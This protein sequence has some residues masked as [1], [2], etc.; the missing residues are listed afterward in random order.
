LG[1]FRVLQ[2]GDSHTAARAFAAAWR[3]HLQA[4][5]GDGGWGF[6][7]PWAS[8]AAP[9]CG[10]SPG[11]TLHQPSLRNGTDGLSGPGGA[12]LQT[13]RAGEA[14]WVE[15]PFRHLRIHLLRQP[16]GGRASIRVD[17]RESSQVDLNGPIE[18]LC[19]EPEL[20][21]EGRRLEIVALGGAV[22][23]LGVA[24]ENG[25]GATYSALGVNGA[26][27]SWLLRSE[28]G[29]FESVL[30]RERPDVVIL[31]FGTNEASLGDFEPEAYRR[32]L[33]SVLSRVRSGLPGGAVLLLGP[34][35]SHL[36]RARPGA[37]TAVLKAQQEAARGIDGLFVPLREA[38]GGEGA[39]Q[40]WSR[41]GLALKDRIHYSAEGYLRLARAGLGPLFA[42]M[43][44]S[45]PGLDGSE[46]PRLARALAGAFELPAQSPR[47]VGRFEAV[48]VES[49]PASRP[50]YT[51]RTEGGRLF[52]TDDPARVEGMRG[53]WVGRG[54][55]Q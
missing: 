34:P 51:F 15:T 22:R 30:R 19:L 27:A 49:A 50:I 20:P 9:K 16:G 48:P 35:D 2:L 28:A 44:R 39:I 40:A 33:A 12:Y 8:T 11:W 7:L 3:S 38:M 25:P 17:G 23:I 55:G 21:R 41:E 46:D 24:L 52:I 54:P 53:T 14:A 13:S 29:I 42:R 36:P 37:L 5:F 31:A 18:A 43:E 4:Q 10:R 26:Q 6:G 32:S 45:R 47:M 1:H